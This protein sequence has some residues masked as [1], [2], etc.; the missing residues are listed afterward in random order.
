[1]PCPPRSSG[2]QCWFGAHWRAS[3]GFGPSGLVLECL[4]GMRYCPN[5][6]DCE[7][8]DLLGCNRRGRAGA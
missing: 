7:C 3:V 8:A 5:C 4:M 1:M 2:E 6:P